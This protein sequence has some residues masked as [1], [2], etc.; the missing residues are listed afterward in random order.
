MKSNLIIIA[1]LASFALVAA[2]NFRGFPDIKTDDIKFNADATF[3]NVTE[4][5][6]NATAQFNNTR[7][8]FNQTEHTLNMTKFLNETLP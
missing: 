4:I 2:Q 3:A 5:V 7:S 8:F 6:K 1:I